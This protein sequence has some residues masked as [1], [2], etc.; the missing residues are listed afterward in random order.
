MPEVFMILTIL[1]FV[2]EFDQ[3]LNGLWSPRY[4]VALIFMRM[5]WGCENTHTSFQV[6]SNAYQ[7]WGPHIFPHPLSILLM[8]EIIFN[9]YLCCLDEI[10]SLS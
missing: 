5:F 7:G 3:S 1:V 9:A 2:F 4:G 8:D 10:L 6:S